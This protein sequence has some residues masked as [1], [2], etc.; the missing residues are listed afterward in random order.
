MEPEIIAKCHG[1]VF[2][3]GDDAITFT[4]IISGYID[5]DD[6][7]QAQETAVFLLMAAAGR[8]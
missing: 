7:E 6:L 3:Q 4:P 8:A 5:W 2:R 1:F